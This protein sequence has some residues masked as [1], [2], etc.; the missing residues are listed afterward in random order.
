MPWRIIRVII[1]TQMIMNT[2]PGHHQPVAQEP[3]APH[4]IIA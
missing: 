3:S 4:H 2:I 1:T